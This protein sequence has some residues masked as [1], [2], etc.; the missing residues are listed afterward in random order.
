MALKSKYTKGIVLEIGG[1]ATKLKTALDG[2]NR[3]IRSTQTE[4][5]TLQ[6]NLQL[7]WNTD[8]FVRAQ[9][10]A[11]RAVVQT[12]DK[13]A[14]LRQALAQLDVQ[15]EEKDVER[16]EAIRRELSSVEVAVQRAA[17]QLQTL[18]NI[19]FDALKEALQ[20]ASEQLDT[21]GNRLS[22]GLTAPLAAAG[23]ASVNYASNT[24]EALNKVDVAF[25][26]SA[27]TVSRWSENTLKQ[28]GLAQGTA[29]DMAALYGDMATSMGYSESEAAKMSTTLVGL[30][31][32]LSSFKNISTDQAQ[33]ALKSI[34]TGET[35]SLKNLG[36]I[37]TQT[38]LKAFA[39][40]QGF[41]TAYEKMDQA[42]QVAVRYQYVL[43]QTQ[44][45]QGDF[46]RT[47][48]GTAN[49]IRIF[50][51]S[52]KQ[53][54]ATAGEELLP[55]ITP[56][57]G[58][59]SEL[60]Q[61]FGDL[62]AGTRKLLVQTGLFLATL[63]PMFKLTAAGTTAV[64]A[65]V[66]AY[67]ALHA[68]LK[69]KQAADA[70]ATASQTAL[71]VAMAANPATIIATAIGA[72][73]A[74]LGSFALVASL[75]SEKQEDLNKKLRETVDAGNDATESIKNNT[76]EQL[77]NLAAAQQM[78]PSI[79]A[80]NK[81]AIRTAQE[82]E[83]LNSLVSTANGLI[84][85]L[86][87]G[88]DAVTGAYDMNTEAIAENIEALKLKA[89]IEA[90]Q[91]VIK[92][93]YR[94]RA[95]LVDQLAAAEQNLADKAQTSADVARNG[96]RSGVEA[97][98]IALE[99]A[100]ETVEALQAAIAQIDGEIDKNA[101]S[102]ADMRGEYSALSGTMSETDTTSKG[103]AESIARLTR[104]TEQHGQV[105]KSLVSD[106]RMLND[107]FAEQ[108]ASGQLSLDTMLS[109]IDAGYAAAISVDRETGVVR[110]NAD[111]YMTLA[112]AKINDQLA[113]IETQKQSIQNEIRLKNEALGAN[114]AATEYL[115]LA[116]ARLLSKRL[117]KDEDLKDLNGQLVT[118]T[119]QQAAL[120]KLR[121]SLGDI[122]SGKWSSGSSSSNKKTA[123]AISDVPVA[124]KKA[125]S[126][127]DYLRSMDQISEADYY[128]RL[129]ALR[130]KYLSESSD[131]WRNVTVKIHQYQREKEDEA[132]K[133]REA[134][135]Q[136]KLDDL[137]YFRDISLISEQTYY[138]K[139]RELQSKYLTEG[140]AEW[141]RVNVELYNYQQQRVADFDALLEAQQKARQE[142]LQELTEQRI[143]AIKAEQ[144]A[145]EERL[146]VA[147]EGINAEIAARRRLR[148][149]EGDEDAVA[150]AQKTLDAAKAQLA[151]ARD[152]YTRAELQKEVARAQSAY[153]AA[154]Q[155]KVDNDWYAQKQ[156]QLD[157]L[158]D[159]MQ[160]VRDTAESKIDSAG[161]WAS[162]Q[163][164]REEAV[165]REAQR[166]REIQMN[167][168]SMTLE[169]RRAAKAATTVAGAITTQTTQNSVNI[170]TGASMLTSGQVAR[171][172]EKV[173]E[174]LGKG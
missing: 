151:Y 35:E 75:T 6:N 111:A 144:K 123:A 88:I 70:G 109:L 61:S 133:A 106:A 57:I 76:A 73:V 49:Q 162:Q 128:T 153:D 29:L 140:S 124:Y 82:Q 138:D 107:A 92:E 129:A 83:K 94:T 169:A 18:N 31:A 50:Q 134:E 142:R 38:N 135:Y 157:A 95:E 160:Q 11:Q 25:G 113:S 117:A 89:Q 166:A 172:V 5:K 102:A 132:T 72:L 77:N 93:Q 126:D 30:A 91:D 41:S 63:G 99:D 24:A 100:R 149:Q 10:L 52:L 51:E 14:M 64:K 40:S 159:K 66:A 37:M 137:K 150:K 22:I 145:E 168:S 158:Q 9:E 60:V 28:Y 96:I 136:K 69:A 87:G 68:A 16:Y 36:V 46:A 163:L 130:D 84:P 97:A 121:Q 19:R 85:G 143:A 65:S 21:I 33:S 34:F 104:A 98:T 12:K 103:F 110:L 42:Q 67:T 141:R 101:K 108:K 131:E 4:L 44:N 156:A 15:G 152:E 114:S 8:A 148:Q 3:E 27:Q 170:T 147:I 39:M 1:N 48:D 146:N 32:D 54:A 119:A 125:M 58:R 23:V 47:S 26:T 105:T 173:I 120:E 167:A 154:V 43:Q 79:D 115:N 164:A 86:V 171:V 81:K 13:A 80:L 62:D 7:E 78:L 174:K 116:E 165:Q 20:D 161:Q 2:V 71:N 112:G 139:L 59:L 90:A 17:A 53:A 74:V 56:I 118:L 155:T 45:A 55:I 127:L 122:A